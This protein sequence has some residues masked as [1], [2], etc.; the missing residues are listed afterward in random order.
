MKASV[1]DTDQGFSKVVN[2]IETQGKKSLTVGI[3]EAEG[4]NSEGRATVAMIANVHEYGYPEGNIPERSWLRGWFDANQDKNEERI[5]KMAAVV[6]AGKMP[7]EQALHRLGLLFVGEIQARFTEG[8]GPPLKE[9]TV[10][11][12]GSSLQLIDTGVMRASIKH[13]VSE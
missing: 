2:A 13:R 4:G 9:K 12:K 5:R 7:E 10:E 6:A 8:I 3:H 11:R 1:K